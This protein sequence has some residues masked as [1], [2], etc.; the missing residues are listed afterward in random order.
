MSQID[1]IFDYIKENEESY[2]AR[3]MEYVSHPSISA[4]NIGIREVA[5]MLVHYLKGLDF[6]AKLIETPGHPF[7]LGHRTVDPSKPTVLLYGHYDV[8]PP[9]PLEAWVSPPFEPEVRD[10][11]IWARGIGDNKGQHFAQLLAIEAHLKVTG[12]LPCN[13]IFCLEGEEEIG[14]PQ[15]ADFVRNHMDEL[16]ADLVVTSDGPLH[17]TGQPV[18]TFGVRGVA[19]FD[20]VAKGASRDVHS[21]NF[22]GVVPNPIWTLVQLLATMK[23]ADGNITVEGITEPVIPATNLEL[24]AASRLPL[25][26]PEVMKDLGLEALDGPLDRPYWDRLMFHP[27][28]TINGFHGGYG[29]P[30]S[31][32]VLPNEAIAKCDVRLVEPLTPDH[33]FERIEAHVAKHAPNVEVVRH[34]GMLPSKTPMDTPFAATLIKAVE[35]ARGV[36]PLLYPTV[37]G[38]LP[39]YVWTKILKKPAFVVPY[40]NADEANHAPNEN[41]EVVRFIDGIRTGAS[42]LFELGQ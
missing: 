42:L 22:G 29:G 33:V 23:D 19:S 8:Q 5:G 16:Q 1:E 28:L 35:R 30:G 2:V 10:G 27:T 26:L 32:T 36:E 20:L 40:A 11:R 17:E 4:H 37:G 12:T 14:S 34:N 6:D 9:D 7:V 31:K 38:S 3:V 39:D 25:D 21:G 41:L 15:I 24:D 18:I 13:I